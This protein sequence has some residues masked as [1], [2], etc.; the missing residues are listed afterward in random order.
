[1]QGY[2]ES[3]DP[4]VLERLKAGKPIITYVKTPLGRVHVIAI[5]PTTGKPEERILKGNPRDPEADRSAMTVKIYSEQEHEYFKNVNKNL[6]KAG[7]LAVDTRA[8]EEIAMTNAISDDE[9]DEILSK[10]NFTLLARLEKFTSPTPVERI[11]LRA[12]ELNK[13]I[14]TIK[15]IEGKLAELQEGTKLMEVESR[16]SDHYRNLTEVELGH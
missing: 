3:I 9:I 7:K 11:L 15:N 12:K 1:M 6:F 4:A 5:E 14:K 10:P 13:G 16:L 8:E 2:L